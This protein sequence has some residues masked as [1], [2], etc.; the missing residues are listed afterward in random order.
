MRLLAD[1]GISPKTVA[2]L[3]DR[4]HD[5]VHLHA[6][7]LDRLPDSAI[8]ELARA[9][10]RVLLTHD[11][12]FAELMAAAREV[13]PSVV[14]FRLRRMRPDSVNQHLQR[15]ISQ[16]EQSLEQG[17]VVSVTEGRARVRL[18]PIGGEEGN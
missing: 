7:S 17:A 13:L 5:A 1:M 12:D 18:L 6:R 9:E 14:V 16:H 10:D 11:L 15:I 4:G 8:L 3:C 2:F